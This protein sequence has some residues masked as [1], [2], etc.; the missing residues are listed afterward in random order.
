MTLNT[1]MTVFHVIGYPY[2]IG[3]RLI[4]LWAHVHMGPRGRPAGHAEEAVTGHLGKKM[5]LRKGC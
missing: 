1:V 5:G 2:P 4:K 3:G